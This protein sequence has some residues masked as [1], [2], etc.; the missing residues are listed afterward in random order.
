MIGEIW[1]NLASRDRERFIVNYEDEY[2]YSNLS[3]IHGYSISVNHI[4]IF[5]GKMLECVTDIFVK[6]KVL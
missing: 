1:V 2:V 6:D 3:S 5:Q 4:E